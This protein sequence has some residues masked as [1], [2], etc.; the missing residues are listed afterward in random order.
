MGPIVFSRFHMRLSELT[1]GKKRSST[2]ELTPCPGS[3]LRSSIL[4]WLVVVT[5][6]SSLDVDEAVSQQ[7]MHPA[8]VI[9]ERIASTR[10]E[11]IQREYAKLTRQTLAK[12]GGQY[13]ARIFSEAHLAVE[14]EANAQR[15]CR[16]R[17][18][19]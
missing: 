19:L 7:P 3:I 11:S 17:R 8:F 12:Y 5:N 6:A 4:L 10:D 13:L 14:L 2:G 1:I 9:A 15:Y 18:A 16:P